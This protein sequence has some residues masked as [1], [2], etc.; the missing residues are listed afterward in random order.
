M[1]SKPLLDRNTPHESF[2]AMSGRD[3]ARLMRAN[4]VSI[5]QLASISGITLKQIRKLREKGTPAGFPSWEI[6]RIIE[7]ALPPTIQAT[8]PIERP[9]NSGMMIPIAYDERG[10][11]MQNSAAD[12][13]TF[14]PDVEFIY[15]LHEKL[16]TVVHADFI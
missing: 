6:H 10:T 12:A 9:Y 5:R 4:G 16:G 11:Q 1:K 2:P 15:H 7:M 13:R 3:I 14:G 8:N